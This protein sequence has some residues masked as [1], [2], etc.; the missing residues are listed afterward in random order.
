M[1]FF[2]T[3]FRFICQALHKLL[4]ARGELFV[5]RLRWREGIAW[6]RHQMETFSAG[7]LCGEF[8]GHWR[9]P[10]TKASDV[11]LWCFLW[12]APWINGWVNNRE[13]GDL[14]RHRAHYDIIVMIYLCHSNPLGWIMSL[15]LFDGF[16]WAASGRRF[17]QRPIYSSIANT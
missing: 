2:Y 8:T 12:S 4:A 3:Y 11:E 15:C 14:R 5:S 17:K 10:N 13:A 16:T 9:V 7:H 6:W 1:T